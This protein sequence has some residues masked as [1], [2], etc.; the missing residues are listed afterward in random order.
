MPELSAH[1]AEAYQTVRERLFRGERY[2]SLNGFAGTG[3]TFLIATLVEE[4]LSEDEDVRLC[5]P[6]HKAAQVAGEMIASDLR[7][8]T[9]HALLG[10]RLVPDLEGGYELVPERDRELP[11]RATVIVDEASMVGTAEWAAIEETKGL[12]WLFV[13]DP[14]Q[15][16]P[17]NEDPSP[18]LQQ[19]GPLLEEVVR[20]QRDNPILSL[21]TN[22]R[23]GADGFASAFTA[24]EGV[25]VT[26]RRQALLESAV[27]AFDTDTFQ[28]NPAYARILA[29]RNRTVR[30]YNQQVRTALFGAHV[31]RFSPGEWLVARDS[32]FIEGTPLLINSEEVRVLATT[33]TTEDDDDLG[34]WTVWRLEV[35]GPEDVAPREVTVLHEKEEERFQQRLRK[36]RDEARAGE[37]DWE[38]YYRLREHFASVDYAYASTIH[39]AQGSTYHTCFLDVRD[40]R[41]APARDRQPL[42]YVAATRPASRLAVLV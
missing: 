29:Y 26:G 19:P 42:L 22:L 18:A 31:P 3:K 2:T 34:R 20:Q 7:P 38:L 17:V 1:Q 4:L 30:W 6:T 15:L 11:E 10:L 16:P 28:D 40:T 37:R 8:T 21:A 24:G 33:Q 23:N 9:L 13:G 12:T 14:A 36:F 39:K 27:R 5:A 32:W 25:A 41:V 35:E